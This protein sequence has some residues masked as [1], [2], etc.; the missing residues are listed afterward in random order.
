MQFD[1]HTIRTYSDKCRAK[2]TILDLTY[3]ERLSDESD[4]P[5]K[6]DTAANHRQALTTTTSSMTSTCS[7]AISTTS[8]G[9]RC[10]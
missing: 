4:M 1:E 8:Q 3:S 6:V 10:C 2:M 9:A 5:K 7:L